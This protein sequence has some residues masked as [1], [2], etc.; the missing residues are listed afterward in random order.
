MLDSI[1]RK[2]LRLFRNTWV[3]KST[4]NCIS[5]NLNTN[6]VFPSKIQ[7]KYFQ[8]NFGIKIVYNTYQIFEDLI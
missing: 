5:W 2:L 1:I 4:F 7:I 3:C 6:Q 8:P